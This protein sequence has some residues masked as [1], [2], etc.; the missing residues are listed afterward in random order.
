MQISR[1]RG[2]DFQP[3][4]QQNTDT[5]KYKKIG[6]TSCSRGSGNEI[7]PSRYDMIKK[8]EKK[9]KKKPKSNQ[10]KQTIRTGN[11]YIV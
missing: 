8:R 2:N 6:E 11:T 9:K 7:S 1:D 4:M 3:C 10:I 5:L